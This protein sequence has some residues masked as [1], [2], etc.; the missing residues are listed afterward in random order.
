MI[1][2]VA[3]CFVRGQS[4]FRRC[5]TILTH[6][7]AAV[8][9]LVVLVDTKML[10]RQHRELS[11][12]TTAHACFLITYPLPSTR[13]AL[14]GGRI[15]SSIRVRFDFAGRKDRYS[16]G[17]TC[18]AYVIRNLWAASYISFNSNDN[19]CRDCNIDKGSAIRHWW[20]LERS[21]RRDKGRCR[22]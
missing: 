11:E 19:L 9:Y 7:I 16:K 12:P 4:Y 6:P 15:Y 14:L 1:E 2:R 3:G 10:E 18:V 20:R 17:G 22:C 13:R 21:R 8:P 5:Y